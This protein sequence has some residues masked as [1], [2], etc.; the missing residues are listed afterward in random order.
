MSPRVVGLLLVTFVTLLKSTNGQAPMHN[1]Y[2]GQGGMLDH[3]CYERPY[4]TSCV[5]PI[6]RYFYNATTKMCEQINNVCGYGGFFSLQECDN[7]CTCRLPPEA[8]TN[9]CHGAV[10]SQRYFFNQNGDMCLPFTYY[11]CGGNGN[12]FATPMECT[13][14]CNPPREIEQ[15]DVMRK[16]GFTS[17]RAFEMQAGLFNYGAAP[18]PPP[19][20]TNPG[21]PPPPPPPSSNPS[22]Q[23]PPSAHPPHHPP[24]PPTGHFSPTSS[25]WNNHPTPTYQPRWQPPPP[26]PNQ[27]PSFMP[28]MRSPRP[29]PPPNN[30]PFG[31]RQRM[32]TP[33]PNNR[34]N[35]GPNHITHSNS[36][37]TFSMS[38]VKDK[39][40]KFAR[41]VINRQTP[42]K[43]RGGMNWNRPNRGPMPHNGPV[44]IPPTPTMSMPQSTV[45]PMRNNWRG[46]MNQGNQGNRR[47]AKVTNNKIAAKPTPSDQGVKSGSLNPPKV[48]A[49]KAT[50]TQ[51]S[52]GFN[53]GTTD[54]YY[55]DNNGYTTAGY[56]NNAQSGWR[57][58]G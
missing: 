10:E 49:A 58:F 20:K 7:K 44:N 3:E 54:Y 42:R 31:N 27:R 30:R 40:K 17:E 6:P 18:P 24:S 9:T 15:G 19:P 41:N 47:N 26:P 21:P 2:F 33:P 56:Y 1:N 38:N 23:H 14:Q 50:T 52:V 25:S 48:K 29:P 36:K 16:M 34:R 5:G 39:L 51:S 46:R 4:Q 22:R 35:I 12:N 45:T 57:N 28:H 55:Y 32:H 37:S 43:D 53:G 13:M 8:G 11:G